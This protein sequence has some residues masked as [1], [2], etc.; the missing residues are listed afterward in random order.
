MGGHGASIPED[1][2]SV[3][4]R[5]DLGHTM[6]DEDDQPAFRRQLARE[7][8]QPVRL[9]GGERGCGL[10]EDQDARVLGQPLG[11]LDD[12]PFGERETAEFLVG[13]QPRE[14]VAVEQFL[15]LASHR[16]A[17]DGPPGRHRLVAKP[18]VLLDGQVGDQRQFLEYSGDAAFARLVGV[19]GAKLLAIDHD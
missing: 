15:R 17:V 10:V 2:E 8:E 16:R 19:S 18:D 3:G 1:G 4:Y 12:L 9:A 11:D 13:K 5:P 14:R 7:L 6:G